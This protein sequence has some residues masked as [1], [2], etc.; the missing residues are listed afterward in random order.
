MIQIGPLQLDVPF[1]QAPL[2]YSEGPMRPARRYGC[3]LTFTG[4]MLDRIALPRRFAA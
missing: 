4:V 1:Y 2:G 3:P